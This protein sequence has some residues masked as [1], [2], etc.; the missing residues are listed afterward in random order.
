MSLRETTR[1]LY[2]EFSLSGGTFK[3][4]AQL[5]LRMLRHLESIEVFG[6]QQSQSGSFQNGC[7]QPQKPTESPKEIELILNLVY[8]GIR[9]LTLINLLRCSKDMPA[10]QYQQ[11]LQGLDV[12]PGIFLDDLSLC[13]SKDSNDLL[14]CIFSGFL[15]ISEDF[16]GNSIAASEVTSPVSAS[17]VRIS[18]AAA[19][20]AAHQWHRMSPSAV[21]VATKWRQQTGAPLGPGTLCLEFGKWLEFHQDHWIS[22]FCSMSTRATPMRCGGDPMSQ[23]KLPDVTQLTLSTTSKWQ[24]SKCLQ[25]S[26]FAGSCWT[27]AGHRHRVFERGQNR[28]TI[29]VINL[30]PNGPKSSDAKVGFVYRFWP[31][32]RAAA[33]KFAAL[34]TR[35]VSYVTTLE[36]RSSELCTSKLI[37]MCKCPMVLGSS[38]DSKPLPY[39]GSRLGQPVADPSP[40]CEGRG[41]DFSGF[42][43]VPI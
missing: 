1:C 41:L 18:S 7:C 14:H 31:R 16:S 19:A 29:T 39:F 34:G 36:N 23:L 25:Q 12:R 28:K 22:R 2:P 27:M 15:R 3:W 20:T 9:F 43:Y 5:D 40:A 8:L 24:W 38:P 30:Q 32:A 33:G 6:N 10:K 11:L 26:N 21:I 13:P 37:Y 17:V 35:L 4:W 42:L